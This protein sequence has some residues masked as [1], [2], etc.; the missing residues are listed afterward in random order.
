MDGVAELLQ[1]GDE[2]S[3]NGSVDVTL[4]D[5]LINGSVARPCCRVPGVDAYLN[6]QHLLS[7]SI[8]SHGRVSSRII[9][10]P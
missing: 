9:F 8:V 7:A 2:G 1:F 3:Y 4:S 6:G 5:A 10:R